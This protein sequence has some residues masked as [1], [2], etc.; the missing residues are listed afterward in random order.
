[1]TR[2]IRTARFTTDKCISHF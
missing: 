1:M 2:I